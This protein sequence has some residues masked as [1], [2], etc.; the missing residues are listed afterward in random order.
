MYYENTTSSDGDTT[1]DRHEIGGNWNGISETV[2][3]QNGESV[4]ADRATL[5]FI[6]SHKKS[7]EAK[8]PVS[9]EFRAG[10]LSKIDILHYE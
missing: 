5:T 8:E 9:L 2:S 6:H 4:E 1:T 10:N 3:N 7:E